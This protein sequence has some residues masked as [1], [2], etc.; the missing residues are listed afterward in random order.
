VIMAVDMEILSER[1]VGLY[2]ICAFQLNY[3][4]C[5][6]LNGSVSHVVNS[7]KSEFSL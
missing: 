3:L 5:F 6:S 1:N 2:F 7:Y 4:I